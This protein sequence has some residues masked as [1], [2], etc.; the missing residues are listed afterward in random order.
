MTEPNTP[1]A[2]VGPH[3]AVAPKASPVARWLSVLAGLVFLGE[4][5]WLATTLGLDS[6]KRAANQSGSPSST[7]S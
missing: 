4:P 7:T 3:P 1:V 5:S 2:P 6:K